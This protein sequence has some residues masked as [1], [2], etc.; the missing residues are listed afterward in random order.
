M[1]LGLGPGFF[2]FAAFDSALIRKRAPDL[3]TSRYAKSA[4]AVCDRFG[5][6][7]FFDCSSVSKDG[8]P[9]SGAAKTSSVNKCKKD[10]CE[11]KAVSADGKKLSGAAKN[12]FMKKCESEA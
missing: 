11:A 6:F 3:L 8:K 2:Y 9:L 4:A 10:T 5:V 1:F 7:F 12:S